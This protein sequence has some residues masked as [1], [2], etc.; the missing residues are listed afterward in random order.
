M[1]SSPGEV[2]R[3][4]ITC[5]NGHELRLMFASRQVLMDFVARADAEYWCNG[6]RE[7]L[8]LSAEWRAEWRPQVSNGTL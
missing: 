1:P 4:P 7:N 8:R 2:V 5:P 3:I 6:C